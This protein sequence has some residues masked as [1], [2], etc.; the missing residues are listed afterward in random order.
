MSAQKFVIPFSRTHTCGEIGAVDVGAEVCLM[1]WVARVRN[2]GGLRFIDLRDRYGLVQLLVDPRRGDLDETSSGLNMEDVIACRGT[3]QRRPEEMVR[4]DKETG[5]FEIAVEELFLLNPSQVPPFTV[6]DDVKAGEDLRLKYR[7][8]DLRRRPM[9]RNIE[10]R[11]RVI[12]AVRKF[13]DE[14]GFLEIETPMLV[15][16]TPEGA[17]DYLVPSRLHPGSFFALPQSPQLYKQILM[18]AG[19]DRYFQI[20]RCMRDEDLRADRQPEHT[21]IDIEMS[22]VRENDVFRLLEELMTE[23]FRV[24]RDVTLET[25]FPV[26]SYRD[27]MD[28]FGSDKPDLRL[29]MELRTL[30][31]AFRGSGIRFVDEAFDRGESVRGFVAPGGAAFNKST[32]DELEATAKSAGAGGLIHLKCR[33]GVL[34]GPMGKVLGEGGAAR[35]IEQSGLEEGGLL[36]AIVGRPAKVSPILGRLRVDAGKILSIAEEGR[37]DFAWVN[38]F[39]LFEWDEDRDCITPSHHFFSMPREE[40]IPL[41]ETEPLKVRSYLYDLVCNGVELASGSI[42]VHNRGLQERILAVG[43]VSREEAAERFGFLLNA[44]EF[45]APPH[46]GIAPGLDRILMLL[47]GSDSIRDVIAFPKTQKATSLMDEAPSPVPS[48]QL[49]ELHIQIKT[50]K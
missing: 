17:R 4:T 19:F 20:A 42:R 15:R 44:L 40:D 25:P 39:P 33:E 37:F 14:R 22:Y 49:E 45:G 8:L 46:G 31:E 34:K 21:Q 30:D 43:G 1:G 41:L 28:R 26:L 13:L 7:Y 50:R 32:I 3:V 16:C 36:L 2:L 27:V 10:L 38:N 35:V 12:L 18:V 24:G 47:S 29:G 23:I 48:E 9:Q 5:E 6:V 11:H